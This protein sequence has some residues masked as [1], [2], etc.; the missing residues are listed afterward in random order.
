M[1]TAPPARLP[2]LGWFVLAAGLLCLI[3]AADP[4]NASQ[5]P[6]PTSYV[7]FD[8]A[9]GTP[10]FPV[11]GLAYDSTFFTPGEPETAHIAFD[12]SLAMLALD[13]QSLGRLNVAVRMDEALD[14]TG[15]PPGT[16]VQ[17]LLQLSLDEWS[18]QFCG[19]S[20][21]GVRLEGWLVS[22]QDSTSA[23]AN[24]IGPGNGRRNLATVITLPV[25]FTAGAPIGA[26]FYFTFGT[27]PGG[28]ATAELTGHYAVVG[29]P[30]GVRSVSCNYVTP[31][32]TGSWGTLKA[33]YR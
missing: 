28:G 8:W 4:S 18:E 9:G 30:A 26:Q 20:G 29:L 15:V 22:G 19:G 23:N 1:P 27:G 12:R 11:D 25:K 33:R 5:T 14:V 7:Q 2:H 6:C 13:A 16:E 10:A 3:Q 21:C 24:Q 32:V 17:G 31:G